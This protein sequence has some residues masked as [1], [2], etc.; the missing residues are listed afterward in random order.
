MKQK[1]FYKVSIYILF[2]FLSLNLY[3]K[4]FMWEVKSN[5]TTIYLLGSIHVGKSGTFPLNNVIE[6]AFTNSSNLVV[7]VDIDSINPMSLMKYMVYSDSNTLQSNLKP[8]VYIKLVKLFDEIGLPELLYTKLKPWAAIM[9]A[10]QFS[11]KES[12]VSAENGIDKYFIDKARGNKKIISLET[13]EYQMSIL[14]EFDKVSNEFVE[15]SLKDFKNENDQIDNMFK[16]WKNGNESEIEKIINE[17]ENDFPSYKSIMEKLLYN[18]NINMTSKIG[19]WL[20]GNETYFVVV[21][22]GHLVGNRGIVNLLR[23]N[24]ELSIIQK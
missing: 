8:E 14:E 15:Y 22:A 4:N 23:K 1:L 10:Q 9:M 19:D 16:A 18:R 7:E 20:K 24:K 12:G 3:S 13:A 6:N 17:E 21:G 2:L 11:M 5:S